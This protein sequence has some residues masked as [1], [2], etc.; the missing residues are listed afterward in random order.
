MPSRQISALASLLGVVFACHAA[1]PE[2]L[3]TFQGHSGPVNCVAFSPDGKVLVSGG[4]DK[5]VRIWDASGKEQRALR[6]DDIVYSVAFSPDGKRLASGGRDASIRVWD[7][8]TGKQ[9]LDLRQPSAFPVFSVSWSPDAKRLAM[10]SALPE[11]PG[12]ESVRVW[13]IPSRQPLEGPRGRGFIAAFSPDGKWLAGV[14]GNQPGP[15]Q[16]TV[17]DAEKGEVAW[18]KNGHARTA[19]GVGFSPDAKRLATSGWDKTIKVWDATSGKEQ[20]TLRGHEADARS[21]VFSPD[22]KRLASASGD[23]T[24]RIWDAATGKELLKLSGHAADVWG[25]AFSPDG[26]RLASASWDKTVRLWRVEE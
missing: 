8:R 16:V 5:A 10:G 17:W 20:L 24:V 25:V 9:L 7:P 21:V 23:K 18:A 26:K 11:D 2:P 3:L 22:G 13:D 1:P 6:H 14:G 12:V 4:D 19:T 15:G